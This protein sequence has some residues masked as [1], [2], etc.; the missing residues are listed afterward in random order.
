[1]NSISTNPNIVLSSEICFLKVQRP[2]RWSQKTIE[3]ETAYA[4]VISRKSCVTELRLFPGTTNECPVRFLKDSAL[5][6]PHIVRC[7]VSKVNPKPDL[8][9]ERKIIRQCF[10]WM[11][12]IRKKRIAA[13]AFS[14]STHRVFGMSECVGCPCGAVIHKFRRLYLLVCQVPETVA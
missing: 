13:F 11:L 7:S 10:F 8:V 6:L 5:T 14:I 9:L 2:F 1:M 12:F 3:K 4:L